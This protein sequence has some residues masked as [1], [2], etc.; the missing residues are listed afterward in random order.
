M[1]ARL[2][3]MGNHSFIDTE[4][5]RMGQ[6]APRAVHQLAPPHWAYK[7]LD[8][9]SA[10]ATHLAGFLDAH[11]P[12]CW[13]YEGI[14]A[15]P[16]TV[17]VLLGGTHACFD[18]MRRHTQ[19]V[20]Q[21]V[22]TAMDEARQWHEHAPADLMLAGHPAGLA[23]HTMVMGIL[24]VTPD[25]FSDGGFYLRPEQAVKHAEEMLDQGADII[26]VGGASSRPGASPVPVEVEYARVVPVV[27]EIVQR[28]GAR[29][30]VDTYRAS[31][32]EAALDAGAVLINDIS[33]MRFDTAMAPLIARRQ[34]AVVLMHMQGTPQTMQ[35][36]PTYRQVIDEVYDFFADRLQFAVQH[37]IARDRIICDPGFGFG[38]TMHHNL[39]LL[40]DLQHFGTLGQP[41]LVGTSRKSFFGQLL[42]REVWDRLEGTI[43]SVVYVALHGAAIVRVHDVGPTVQALHLVDAIRSDLTVANDGQ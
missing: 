7:L 31:V 32:A 17:D 43:A 38:K 16:G 30:S 27:H 35:Q 21:E 8:V 10:T 24:N 22:M 20:W 4:L 18:T 29:V 37:G 6:Q 34:A 25:S 11:A 28:F 15:T 33:A 26:D 19:P 13:W 9:P 41:L 23:R 39:D 12:G 36:A 1:R 3:P 42:Q 2:L 40:R 5:A 14:G